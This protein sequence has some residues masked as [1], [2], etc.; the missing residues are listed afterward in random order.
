[1]PADAT[2]TRTA[3][4]LGAQRFQPTLAAAVKETG[5]QGRIAIV[6]AGW[7]ERE[8][9]ELVESPS[10]L[11][12]PNTN[13]V[14]ID[15]ITG[16]CNETFTLTGLPPQVNAPVDLPAEVVAVAL[17]EFLQRRADRASR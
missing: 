2:P 16:G 3:V 1:M 7:Q 8:D 6:T 4:L 14:A 15:S 17:A 5:V 10:A 9:E 11:S 13:F 12:C